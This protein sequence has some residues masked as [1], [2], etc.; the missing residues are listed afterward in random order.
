MR[1][2]EADCLCWQMMFLQVFELQQKLKHAKGISFEAAVLL[3]A[4]P[5]GS[6]A[7]CYI[8][9]AQSCVVQLCT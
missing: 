9:C 3:A 8:T 7:V 4:P 6:A 5:K 2:F 1:V